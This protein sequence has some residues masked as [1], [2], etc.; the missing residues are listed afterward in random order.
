MKTLRFARKIHIQA[1]A[2]ILSLAIPFPSVAQ[3]LESEA[4]MGREIPSTIL[5]PVQL[6]NLE[7][8]AILQLPTDNLN[9]PPENTTLST[10]A[11]LNP[12]VAQNIQALQINV[13]QKSQNSVPARVEFLSIPPASANTT[14]QKSRAGESSINEKSS[15]LLSKRI[16][17][18]LKGIKKNLEWNKTNVDSNPDPKKDEPQEI[19]AEINSSSTKPAELAPF[20]PVSKKVGELQELARKNPSEAWAKA[21]AILNDS[22]DNSFVVKSAALDI[23]ET[24]PV[25]VY[26]PV[27]INLLQETD[28]RLL[29]REMIKVLGKPE[30]VIMTNHPHIRGS[31]LISRQLGIPLYIPDIKEVEED[32]AI[33][34]MFIDLYNMKHGIQYGGSTN[35]PFGMKAYKIPGRHEFAL[36]FGDFMIVGDSAYGVN[37]KLN[38]YPSGIW[39]DETGSKS[40]ATSDALI[41]LIKKT[42]A[43]GLLS[44]HNEDITS[45]LQ[46]ML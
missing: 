4:S 1:L 22:S 2:V 30:A 18:L 23:L 42:G 39:P 46:E 28:Q 25:A 33:S 8:S 12:I 27:L 20:V 40:K 7:P 17:G 26:F 24:A 19:K 37:G 11:K 38:F 15:I 14:G 32:E 5:N 36:I 9:L 35:L 45:G 16:G 34:N 6:S 21:T 44:G 10:E 29:E 3:G 43:R 41:P 31:P 13:E